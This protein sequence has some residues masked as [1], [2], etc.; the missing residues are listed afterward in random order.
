[1]LSF[2]PT[3]A[4][5]EAEL[6]SLLVAELARP[7]AGRHSPPSASAAPPATG[8]SSPGSADVGD[9]PPLLVALHGRGEAGRGLE[10]GARGWR[11]DYELDT[12]DA[13]LHRGRLT[14]ADL[15]GFVRPERLA[16]L[17]ASLAS[18]PYGGVAVAC[19]YTPALSDRSLAG[20]RS[21]ARF[22]GEELVPRSRTELGSASAPARTGIDGVSMGGRLALLVG[23]S[24]PEWFRAVAAM[25][26]AITAQEAPWLSELAA[27]ARAAGLA[28]LR[29]VTSD[30]DPFRGA[31][32]ALSARFDRDGVTH[33]LVVTPGPHDYVWNRGPGGV[34]M[35]LGVER[36]LRG[37]PSP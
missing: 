15:R 31:V 27:Q 10:V 8:S 1:M 19:P 32:E 17:N 26:P 7:R 23:L 35:L 29:L 22:V 18:E 28:A 16:R 24:H 9:A 33:D 21:F 5:S 6:A 34:E 2:P 37:L 25:Q 36:A 30:E 12:V 13:A 4:R 14:A 11:D 3:A 20:S